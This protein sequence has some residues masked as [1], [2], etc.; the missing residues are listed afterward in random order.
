[1]HSLYAETETETE[2]E[3]IT[4]KEMNSYQ[5]LFHGLCYCHSGK[6]YVIVA[7]GGGG[8]VT[9]YVLIW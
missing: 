4:I 9:F 6:V 1:M 2:R 8:H 7:G 3:R 5:I